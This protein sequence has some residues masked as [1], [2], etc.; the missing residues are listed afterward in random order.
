MREFGRQC[1]MDVARTERTRKPL[2]AFPLTALTGL[3]VQVQ[4]VWCRVGSV[5]VGS[6]WCF[7]PTGLLLAV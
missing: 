6:L 4:H 2:R 1:A 3:L 7:P 5:P